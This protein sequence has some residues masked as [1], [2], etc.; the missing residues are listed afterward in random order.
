MHAL[1]FVS[2]SQCLGEAWR[3]LA[4]VGDHIQNY[5]RMVALPSRKHREAYKAPWNHDII[6][7][8]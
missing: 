7:D 5:L 2:M 3:F 4:L 8:Y 1:K 6:T